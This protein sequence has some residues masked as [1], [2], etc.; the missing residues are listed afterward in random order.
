V[1]L[2]AHQNGQ[3]ADV[4][5]VSVG[6]DQSISCLMGQGTKVW[7]RLKTD[8]FRMHPGVQDNTGF[9]TFEK[10]GV[11]PNLSAAGKVTKLH[12]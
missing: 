6:D 5:M 1:R 2:L 10:V 3:R 4:V 11:S 9:A 12:V 7:Q 8:L